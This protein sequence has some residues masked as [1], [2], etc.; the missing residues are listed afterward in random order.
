MPITVTS[1]EDLKPG[2]FYEDCAF[3]PCL[4]TK[5][6]LDGGEIVFQGISLVDGSYHRECGIPGCG[7]RKLTFEEAIR[8]K[9]YGPAD[10]ELD[11]AHT[12]WGMAWFKG[13]S[14]NISLPDI[15][16]YSDW[17]QRFAQKHPE[18]VAFITQLDSMRMKL[19]QDELLKGIPVEEFE[20]MLGDLMEDADTGLAA[21]SP[22]PQRESP[23]G[24]AEL[25]KPVN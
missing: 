11:E 25:E 13:A 15:P 22:Q 19:T 14:K 5:V 10:A 17:S 3:H 1:A 24:G 9:F 12:W 20:K 2:D 4:C 16:G 7:V 23:S 18:L 8:W 21:N 6:L